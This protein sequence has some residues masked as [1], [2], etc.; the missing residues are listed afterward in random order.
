MRRRAPRTGATA[1]EA[2][3]SRTKAVRRAARQRAKLPACTNSVDH[4]EY[5]PPPPPGKHSPSR[6]LGPHP[7]QVVQ[8]KRPFASSVAKLPTHAAKA[9]PAKPG[10]SAPAHR[11][12][13]VVQAMKRKA[14]QELR[15]GSKVLRREDPE[16]LKFMKVRLRQGTVRNGLCTA[17]D[18]HFHM[19]VTAKFGSTTAIS[20][21]DFRQDATDAYRVW[22]NGHGTID[23]A[24]EAMLGSPKFDQYN[25][26]SW[27]QSTHD[28]Y[29]FECDPDEPGWKG[30]KIPNIT[31]VFHIFS[32]SW[33]M[34]SQGVT[35]VPATTF[36]IPFAHISKE[37]GGECLYPNCTITYEKGVWQYDESQ[38]FTSFD[39]AAA[40]IVE[41]F[42]DEVGEDFVDLRKA[43]LPP[44]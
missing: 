44:K 31:S 34:L 36:Y 14:T 18:A 19:V 39:D 25:E 40:L 5:M 38:V 4:C 29:L 20:R 27:T 15:H 10:G 9:G 28:P 13:V 30:C 16:T 17:S 1:R 24:R 26:D 22:S 35:L 2:C 3:E 11:A 23:I 43:L 37:F 42:G 8:P 41:K 12:T 7:A 6:V 33:S 32:V 21:M